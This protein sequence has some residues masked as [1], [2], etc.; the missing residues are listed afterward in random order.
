MVLGNYDLYMLVVLVGIGSFK[1]KDMFNDVLV[2]KYCDKLIDWLLSCLLMYEND[3]WV[4][5]Y[6][7][8]YLGWFL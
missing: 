4:M 3:D 6:V 7:G 2:S 5:S 1:C 8:I